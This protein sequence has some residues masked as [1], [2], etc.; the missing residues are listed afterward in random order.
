MPKKKVVGTQYASPIKA[1][2]A[3]CMECSNYQYTEVTKCPI[4]DCALY[5]YRFGKNPFIKGRTL[6]DEQKKEAAERLA[7]ARK[8]RK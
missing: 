4:E 1:I 6:T 5:A 3:K 7:K 2:R 8:A